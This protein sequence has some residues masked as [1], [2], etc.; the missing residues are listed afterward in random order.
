MLGHGDRINRVV[1]RRIEALVDLSVSSLS[2]YEIMK[3][4]ALHNPFRFT[5][6]LLDIGI[7]S[8]FQSLACAILGALEKMVNLVMELKLLSSWYA[9]CDFF[10]YFYQI[11]INY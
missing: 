9:Y 5:I 4:T 3:F 2:I 10:T 1:P 6:Y 11:M 8:R 7:Q